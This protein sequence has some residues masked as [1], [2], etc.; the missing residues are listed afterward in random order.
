MTGRGTLK[1][2]TL[3]G[4]VSS[5]HDVFL[6]FSLSFF[7]KKLFLQAIMSCICCLHFLIDSTF[8]K[9]SFFERACLIRKMLR[10]YFLLTEFEVRTASFF[11]FDLWPK[12]EARGP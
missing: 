5:K 2:P 6:S 7:F 12:R 10:K 8:T 4:K 9:R 3:T 1:Y 11:P